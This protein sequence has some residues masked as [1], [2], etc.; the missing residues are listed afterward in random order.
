MKKLMVIL[1]LSYGLHA[2]DTGISA[3]AAV[4]EAKE[5]NWQNW[6]FAA[7]FVVAASTALY[8]LTVNSGRNAPHEEPIQ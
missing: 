3:Q 5:N 6:T 8:L 2:Q 1:A 4:K 7:V